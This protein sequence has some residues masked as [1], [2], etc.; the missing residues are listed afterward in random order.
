MKRQKIIGLLIL[1]LCLFST[2]S[3]MGAPQ[4]LLQKETF[5]SG[6]PTT[7]Q[8]QTPSERPIHFSMS[9]PSTKGDYLYRSFIQVPIGL[10]WGPDNQ[11]Y[12]AD[13]LGRHVV[14]VTPQGEISELELKSNPWKDD[15]PRTL[16]FSL[17]GLLYVND[18]SHIYRIDKDNQAHTLVGVGVDG[19]PIGSI[20]FSPEG[21]LFYTERSASGK[22]RHW[23]KDGTSETIVKDLP[24]AEN[25]AFASDGT[26]YVS[27]MNKGSV[28][29]VNVKSGE[30]NLFYSQ[31]ID[32]PFYIAVDLEGDIWIR[33]VNFLQQ[34]SPDGKVKPYKVDGKNNSTNREFYMLAT[35]SGFVFDN[36]GGLWLN[37]Y[38]SRVYKFSPKSPGTKDPEYQSKIISVG[39]VPSSVAV[40]R[41]GDV[42]VTDNMRH[43]V[44]KI[45]TSGEMMS[46]GNYGCDGD[47]AIALDQNDNIYV[48]LPC[49]RIVTLDQNGNFSNYAS[50]V[51]AR[52]MFG[53]DG[54]LYAIV[55]ASNQQKSLVRITGKNKYTT[56]AKEIDGIPLGDGW[57]D[58][59][60]WKEGLYIFI[61]RGR[62]LFS[63][64]YQGIGKLINI[65][66]AIEGDGPAPMMASYDGKKIFIIAHGPYDLLLID[67]DGKTTPYASMFYGDPWAMAVSSDGR[68]LYIGESGAIDRLELK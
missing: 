7:L 38:T 12:V 64:N 50:L 53:E 29:K 33:G 20:A 66:P 54:A 62:Y 41:R 48:G 6:A 59:A 24:Y 2:Y 28:Y 42:Y 46:I 26:L 30:K 37:S 5:P 44:L 16:A 18:H 55:T 61:E 25:M 49:G 67:A 58:I 36:E 56:L 10:A 22:V 9:D 4:S 52:M 19:G 8:T 39:L 34:L 51:S 13:W 11:L 1:T 3:V 35:S 68:H 47:A 32:D 21:E 17:D 63:T 31:E 57:V 45:N 15:G 65:Q 40:S 14:R 43:E 60:V 23:K 27:Q